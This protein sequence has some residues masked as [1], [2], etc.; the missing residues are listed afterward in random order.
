M[1]RYIYMFMQFN[2]KYL[3]GFNLI[4]RWKNQ[5][6]DYSRTRE[7]LLPAAYIQILQGR[8]F[9]EL[10]NHQI[11]GIYDINVFIAT[12][13]YK[14][15]ELGDAYQDGALDLYYLADQVGTLHMRSMEDQD[16]AILDELYFPHNDRIVGD[17]LTYHYPE[18]LVGTLH[19]TKMIDISNN[20]D[21]LD[22]YQV[23]FRTRVNSIYNQPSVTTITGLTVSVITDTRTETII[24]LPEPPITYSPQ[25]FDF[26]VGN[27]TVAN[28]SATGSTTY[29]YLGEVIPPDVRWYYN[30][31]EQGLTY[32]LHP[33]VTYYVTQVLDGIESSGVPV[34]VY[35]L[36]VYPVGPV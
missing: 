20:Y 15:S 23:S 24:R 13:R 10:P 28:L 5:P 4:D 14:G 31:I 35:A 6:N 18:Y 27:L 29:G 26:S 21:D 3:G 33:D 19:I 36:P 1:L 34:S 22:V 30:N 9:E 32:S 16:K 17:G 12:E 7:T 25:M 11:C 2:L 8:D